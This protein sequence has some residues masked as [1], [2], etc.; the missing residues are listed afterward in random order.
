MGT[1][2]VGVSRQINWVLIRP[3]VEPLFLPGLLCRPKRVSSSEL[4]GFLFQAK[5]G[6]A[7][8]VVC[9]RGEDGMNASHSRMIKISCSSRKL[10]KTKKGGDTGGDYP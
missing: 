3:A 7:N 6:S 2:R 4:F 1:N 10:G 8:G 5:E 9:D